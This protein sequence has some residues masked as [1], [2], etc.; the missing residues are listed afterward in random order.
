MRANCDCYNLRV[1]IYI[2]ECF[3]IDLD[4]CII[5]EIIITIATIVSISNIVRVRAVVARSFKSN[6]A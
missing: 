4:K 1:S 5:F 6:S 3:S 2:K